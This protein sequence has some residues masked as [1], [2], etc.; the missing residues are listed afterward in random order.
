MKR[1]EDLRRLQVGI[2]VWTGLLL[3]VTCTFEPGA[4]HM[5]KTWNR[6]SVWCNPP[7]VSC[8]CLV[9][10]FNVQYQGREHTNGFLSTN[11]PLYSVK[12]TR[13]EVKGD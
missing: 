11:V 10:W 13:R 2:S 4:A 12:Q 7:R 8:T 3:S 6:L 5:S 9:M 1:F